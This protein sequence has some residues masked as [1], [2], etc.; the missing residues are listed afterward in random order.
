MKISHRVLLTLLSVA[1]VTAAIVALFYAWQDFQGARFWANTRHDLEARGESFD[2]AT[3]I[4]PPIPD[5]QNLAFAPFF[6]DAYQY[7]RDPATGL[8]TYHHAGNDHAFR[9][10]D[11]LPFGING[12]KDAQGPSVP[13]WTTGHALD[14]ARFQSYFRSHQG[15]PRA[16]APQTPAAAVLLALTRYTPQLDQLVQGIAARPRCRFPINWTQQPPSKINLPQYNLVQRVNEALRLRAC[17]ALSGGDTDAALRDVE[18]GFQ[19]HHDMESEPLLIAALVDLTDLQI[20]LQPIWEGLAAHRWSAAQLARVQTVLED[21]DVLKSYRRA[22]QGDRAIY[23]EGARRAMHTAGGIYDEL[24]V[25]AGDRSDPKWSEE[26]MYRALSLVPSGWVDESAAVAAQRVQQFCIDPVDV[27]GHR[28]SAYAV[29]TGEHWVARQRMRPSIYLSKIE[30]PVFTSVALRVGRTQ[31]AVG[32]A[33]VA[34]AVERFY[35]DHHAYPAALSELIPAYSARLPVDL[36]DG[37]P[38]RYQATPEGRYRLWCVG[39][40]ERDEGGLT[41]MPEGAAKP[42]DKQGDW[43]WQYD[44]LQPP[45]TTQRS[46]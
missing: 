16:D 40:N 1:L 44:P 27:P 39:W 37:K 19:L 34:C 10:M 7:R 22:V 38:L 29:T 8:L 25:D 9:V 14:L 36:I 13:G 12:D 42:D 11:G 15:F 33:G 18:L 4:P 45:P 23:F 3:F 32:E 41:V 31:A 17:A 6:A 2:A 30:L 20:L 35:V 24:L 46:K 28:L 5:D 21:V 43:V 26:W